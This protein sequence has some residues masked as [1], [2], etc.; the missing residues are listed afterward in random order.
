MLR[1]SIP[2]IGDV[3]KLVGVSR[4]TV[5]RAFSRPHLI[6]DETAKRV[7]DA[8]KKIGYSPNPIARALITGRQGN[9]AIIVSDIIN[10]FFPP[11]LRAAQIG[12]EAS[13][14]NVFL[15]D[16]HGDIEREKRLIERLVMQVDGFILASLRMPDERIQELALRLPV[17]LINRDV[18]GVPRVLIDSA[19]GIDAAITHLV[20]LR[21]R[22]LAYL[23]G[24]TAS[25]SDQQRRVAIRRAAARYKVNIKWIP[26]TPPTFDGGKHVAQVLQHTKATAA[27]AFD[28]FVAHGV[29]AGLT[30]L[31][32][33]VP[34]DFSIIGCDDVLGAL[35]H[36]ALTS[37]SARCDEAGRMAIDL[38]TGIL[39]TRKKLDARCVLE[40]NLLVRATTARLSKP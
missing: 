32:V 7:R 6:G 14:L 3:A 36:P 8:A 5:S 22:Y 10:P 12:A 13:G 38:L 25:W 2:N 34:K 31:G 29:L 24:P 27:I 28:D 35:T 17:V 1:A 21:H 37:I 26:A 23:C 15:G 39:H 30:E 19:T 16:C 4:A 11:L 40:T 9:I 33:D 18:P 20:E